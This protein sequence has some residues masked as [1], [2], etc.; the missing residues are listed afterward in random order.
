MDI[1]WNKSALEYATTIGNII[2]E[3]NH[4]IF[5]IGYGLGYG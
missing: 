3:K 2:K 1:P 4:N 5:S